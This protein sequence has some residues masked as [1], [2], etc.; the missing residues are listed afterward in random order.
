MDEK[1]ILI[2]DD[3]QDVLS[4]LKEG[5]GEQ[6]YSV[7]ATDNGKDGLALAKSERLNVILLDVLMPG[8]YGG[9]VAARLKETPET[10]NI[11]II[12]LS[13]LYSKKENVEKDYTLRDGVYVSKPYEIEE[14]VTKIKKLMREEKTLHE[15]A[16]V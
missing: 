14:L 13:C 1:K 2:V 9:V 12:F 5:L 15:R 8:M 3:E 10:K 16:F 7:I 6:G 11:P 4:V